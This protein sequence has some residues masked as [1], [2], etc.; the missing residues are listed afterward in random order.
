MIVSLQV[1][2]IKLAKVLE[3]NA[4]YCALRVSGNRKWLTHSTGDRN[5]AADAI[6]ISRQLFVRAM[7]K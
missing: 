7:A 4:L 3:V 1:R 2:D 6:T 5:E